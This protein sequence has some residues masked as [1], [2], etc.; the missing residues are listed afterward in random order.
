MNRIFQLPPL[1]VFLWILGIEA[2]FSLIDLSVIPGVMAMAKSTAIIFP[3]IENLLLNP[4]VPP[5]VIP[6]VALT[7]VLIPAKVYVAYLLILRLPPEEKAFW[8]SF[9]SSDAT[10]GRK[11][12]STV[13]VLLIC[14]LFV[15]WLIFQYGGA[16]YYN[17]DTPPRSAIAKFHL[18]IAGGLRMW[19]GW[20]LMHL[21][22]LALVLGLILAFVDEWIRFI[23]NLNK[24]EKE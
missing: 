15:W 3:V 21:A 4:L 16:W 2:I 23:F 9:P 11:I 20:A 19:L 14:I 13:W 10:V 24:M 8:A 17:T 6:Y 22:L 18:V 5:E 1:K 7:S 12:S